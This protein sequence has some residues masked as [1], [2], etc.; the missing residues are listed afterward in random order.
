MFV[1]V[2]V[3]VIYGIGVWCDMYSIGMWCDVYAIGMWCYVYG[4]GM[5]YDVCG[6]SVCDV[7]GVCVLCVQMPR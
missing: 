4:I 1:C 2:C 7:Y 6:I 3:Y 5:W